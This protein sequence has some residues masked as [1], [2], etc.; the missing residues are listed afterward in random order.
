MRSSSLIVL[1][2]A[3]VT[4]AS[5]LVCQS[6]HLDWGTWDA[7]PDSTD[8]L[9]VY[10]DVRFAS[11]P[12]GKLRFAAPEYPPASDAGKAL[13]QNP[14]CVAMEETDCIQPPALPATCFGNA[15]GNVTE[16]CLFLD[17]FVPA[18]A[19]S[20]QKKVPVIVWFYGGA[21]VFG[22]KTQYNPA[23]FNFYGGSGIVSPAVSNSPVIYVAPNY[24][25]GA[26][27]W[28]SGTYMEENA[29]PNAGLLDQRAALQFVKDHIDQLNGDNTHVSVWG[30]SAG[31]SSIL[32][33]MVVPQKSYPPLFTK[34]LLQSPAYQFLWDRK[35]V[36]ND[37]FTSFA[38]QVA[39]KVNAAAENPE[40]QVAD[41][42][43]L[44]SA[45]L[46]HLIEVNQVLFNEVACKGIFPVGP[47]VD[48][49]LILDL[50]TNLFNDPTKVIPLDSV[51]VS[52]VHQEVPSPAA[53]TGFSFIPLPIRENKTD[54]A[55]FD[56]FLNEFLVGEPYSEIRKSIEAQYPSGKYE[57][58]IE[59]A[60]H[61][62]M[63][64]S[65]LCNTRVAIDG[66][67]N[68]GKQVW[69]MDYA[70]LSLFGHANHAT[71]LLPTFSASGISYLDL[72]ECLL[73]NLWFVPGKLSKF[74]S[75]KLG[76]GMISY[77]VSFS[78]T[79]NPNN[80]PHSQSKWKPAKISDG[81]VNNVMQPG[82][83]SNPFDDSAIVDKQTTDKICNFWKDVAKNITIAYNTGA[84]GHGFMASPSREEAIFEDL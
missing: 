55:K 38:Q 17:I 56:D 52:H 71:D 40:C 33:H 11:S 67:L 39:A 63:D 69:A 54:R 43:C 84:A 45:D 13:K 8:S 59:R 16:D 9:C 6:L 5:A 7:S 35:G 57:N 49:K 60:Q 27:G 23:E 42:D 25:L 4:T 29:Q 70:F 75:N 24:P 81:K 30:E 1:Q 41:I 61:V 31:A 22:S 44:R 14:V 32:H 58:Q 68:Q 66:Y 77:F 65:F 80:T 28:L 46:G 36:L 64:S 78:L 53:T 76:P 15:Y 74:I 83:Y 26:F 62:I 79:G 37:T 10:R 73:D 3:L 12:T 50:P 48:G 19:V 72:F 21:Y 51:L 20:S 18:A 2:P 47:A 34:A 82:R